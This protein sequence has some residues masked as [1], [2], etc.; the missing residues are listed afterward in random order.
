MR[1][2]VEGLL[3]HQQISITM[4]TSPCSGDRGKVCQITSSLVLPL[5]RSFRLQK[6]QTEYLLVWFDHRVER[7]M[8]NSLIIQGSMGLRLNLL[9][10]FWSRCCCIGISLGTLGTLGTLGNLW[11]FGPIRPR[12][13][14][15]A[16]DLFPRHLCIPQRARTPCGDMRQR[17]IQ[18]P[19]HAGVFG[20][21]KVPQH[22]CFG[23]KSLTVNTAKSNT[24]S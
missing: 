16:G 10:V 4:S 20:V 2:E 17:G 24:V 11:L 15:L 8:K 19:D 21:G 23:Q 9:Q 7:Q 3:Y 18:N 5:R 22:D 1:E 12:R 14:G 13:R 6:I